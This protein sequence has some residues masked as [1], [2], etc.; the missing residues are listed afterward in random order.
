MSSHIAARPQRIQS[1]TKS[2]FRNGTV[3]AARF[4]PDGQTI[5]YG[6]AWEGQPQEIFSTRFD[7]TDSRT[8]GLPAAQI[9]S[10]SSKGEMAISLHPRPPALSRQ[11]GTLARVPLAGGAPA[12]VL[13]KVFWAD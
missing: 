3:W 9:L 13:D 4:A 5:L 12:E 6:A 8:L 2:T 1:F 11:G 10:V 7:S